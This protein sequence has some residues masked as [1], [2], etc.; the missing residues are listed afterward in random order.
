MQGHADLV[1]GGIL[2]QA[3][4]T[5]TR[6]HSLWSKQ[7]VN[8]AQI[9]ADRFRA[10]AEINEGCKNALEMVKQYAKLGV[11]LMCWIWLKAE[12]DITIQQA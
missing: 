4:W 12:D 6:V 10:S 2:T 9:S 11:T 1:R 3:Y 8:V 5:N 7:E